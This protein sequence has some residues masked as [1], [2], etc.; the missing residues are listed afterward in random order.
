MSLCFVELVPRAVEVQNL[1][2]CKAVWHGFWLDIRTRGRNVL[3]PVI[4]EI[5]RLKEADYMAQM[6]EYER[7]M[8]IRS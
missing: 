6:V 2:A 5:S 3:S 4:D 7:Y 8:Q 1:S